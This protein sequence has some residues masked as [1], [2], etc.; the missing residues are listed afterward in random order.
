[1]AIRTSSPV[2]LYV[3]LIIVVGLVG[4]YLAYT[5]F[6]APNENPIP[7]APISD[8]DSLKQFKGLKIDFSLLDNDSYKNLQV[9]GQIP[10][11]PGESGKRDI[12]APY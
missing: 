7:P 11:V 8:A 6:I 2:R 12:F 3:L 4:G 9:Y 1:M 5:Q 10:V